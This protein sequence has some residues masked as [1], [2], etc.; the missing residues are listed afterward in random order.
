MNSKIRK[1]K[2]EKEITHLAFEQELQEITICLAA[3]LGVNEECQINV[4]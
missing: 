4:I 1:T 2:H 3:T